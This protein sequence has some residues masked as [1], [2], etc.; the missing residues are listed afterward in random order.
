[1]KARPPARNGRNEG[2]GGERTVDRALLVIDMLNDFVREGASLDCGP[3]AREIVPRIAGR[4][5]AARAEGVPVVYV[6]DSH[7][8]DDPEFEMFPP[9]CVAG[10]EGAK[11]VD[12][13]RPAPSDI[14]VPKRRY[15]GFFGSDLDLYLR[16]LGARDLIL[17]GVCTN[18]C[19][20]YTAADA[21]MLGYRV[22]VPR[23]S[24]ATFDE[25]AGRFA[26]KEMQRTLGA[27]VE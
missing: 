20:L 11:V 13:L 8:E 1:V 17:T 7:R 14:V 18:I 25:D 27:R 22:T 5:R 24:V 4:I 21:R 15:S 16:E 2:C 6:C 3:A 9:H 26:L 23:D 19:V 12:E 10:T